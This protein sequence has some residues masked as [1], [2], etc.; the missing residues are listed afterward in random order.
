[1]P[2]AMARANRADLRRLKAILEDAE[3]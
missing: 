3:V 2:R 1:M